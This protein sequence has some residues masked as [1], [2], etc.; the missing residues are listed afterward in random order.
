MYNCGQG[1]EKEVC[2]YVHVC[3]STALII[4]PCIIYYCTGPNLMLLV[5]HGHARNRK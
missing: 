1:V 4:M 3:V 2:V 5:S